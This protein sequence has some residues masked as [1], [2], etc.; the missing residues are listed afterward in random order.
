[1][2]SVAERLG[3]KKSDI[4]D[5]TASDAA[6]K[7][8]HAETHMIEEAKL[9]FTERGVKLEALRGNS[10]GGTA[11]LVKNL[12]YGTTADEIRSL[13]EPYGQIARLLFPPSGTLAIV[14]FI[15]A[16][17]AHYA[18]KELAYR[19]HR[20]SVLFLQR[21]AEDLF[22][23]CNENQ[24]VVKPI[25]EDA[26]SRM[27]DGPSNM[28]MHSS[29]T[30]FIRNLSF[31]TTSTR[32]ME[33][34]QPMEGFISAKVKTKPDPNNASQTLS[35]GYGFAEFKAARQAESALKA[36]DGCHLDG[37]DLHVQFAQRSLDLA[38][39]KRAKS[40]S[41]ASQALKTKIVIK[42]LPFETT[43]KDVRALFGP[44]GQLRSVRVPK[45]F[46]RSTRGFAFADFV[47][48]KEAANAINALENT[49]LLGRRLV[50]EFASEEAV[51][52]EQEI[53]AIEER[54]GKQT[55]AINLKKIKGSGRKKFNV[56][57]E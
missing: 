11:L 18:V 30:L 20:G 42:N 49:H 28:A 13:F 29:S 21:A 16:T 44:Y 34:C 40:Q 33:Y 9:Y 35:M 51:D 7:Q 48:G 57:D 53:R 50:L 41:Q 26:N 14:E 2:A 3:I 32:L 23:N 46:D 37:H 56:D 22:S 8:A 10:G 6:V 45:K 43:K 12:A 52:P 47:S 24:S 27:E 5:P 38:E 25:R 15:N 1:M 19:N 4:L 17:D 54:I 39:G 31:A 36:L 55:D